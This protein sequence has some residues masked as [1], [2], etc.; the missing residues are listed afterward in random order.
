MAFPLRP[1]QTTK[2]L[3]KARSFGASLAGITPVGPVLDSPSSRV[4]H[5]IKIPVCSGSVIVLA[6]AHP[7]SKPH[8]D[9]WGGS[10]GT[11][12]N[13]MLFDISE[14]LIQWMGEAFGVTARPLPYQVRTGGVYLKDAAVLAGLGVIGANNLLIT[15]DFGPRVRLGALL[16][17][18]DV[19][20]GNPLDFSPCEGCGK[21]CI[22]LCPKGAFPDGTFSRPQCMKQ[23]NDDEARACGS[24]GAS[25]PTHVAYCRLCELA[26]LVGIE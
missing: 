7:E 24:D 13:R 22:D 3:K 5:K 8:L 19:E 1:G 12:G 10:R 16:L 23:M 15:R 6:L 25:G 11:A 20:P 26:C 9:Y 21:P 2:I 18:A 17:D 14:K 4:H